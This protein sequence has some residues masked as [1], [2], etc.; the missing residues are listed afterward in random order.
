MKDVDA[1][2]LLGCFFR[3]IAETAIYDVKKELA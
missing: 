1:Y 3:S 2:L